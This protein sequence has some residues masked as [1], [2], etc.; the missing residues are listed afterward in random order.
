MPSKRCVVSFAAGGDYLKKME[1]LKASVNDF[2]TADFLGFKDYK[3]IGCESHQVVPYK[4]KPY[5]I[6]KA[7]DMGYT[8]VLWA[9]SPVVAIKDFD[10]VFD[11]IEENSYLF[12]DNVGWDLARWTNDKA[13]KH[14]GITREEAKN[15]KIIMACLMGF[16]FTNS[17]VRD[18]FI[19]YKA[20]ADDLYPGSWT[21]HRH[22][23]SVMSLILDRDGVNLL[24]G[25]KTFFA[26][27][28]EHYDNLTVSESVCLQ[29]RGLY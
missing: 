20:L 8:T 4:F 9:D 25:H 5:A 2:S 3:T 1:R 28:P 22:D 19:E 6:Q 12:F 15:K 27:W 24:E 14:F 29:S 13:L 7:I 10:H 26:Y 17:L 18:I 11:Y 16:D 23:Q 21:D